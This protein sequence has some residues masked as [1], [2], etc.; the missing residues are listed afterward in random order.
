MSGSTRLNELGFLGDW[1][2]RYW[3]H[4]EPN[5]VRRTYNHAEYFSERGVIMQQWG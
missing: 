2:E 3:A 1:I 5:A 4:I